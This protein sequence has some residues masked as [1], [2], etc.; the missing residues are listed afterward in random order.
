MQITIPPLQG[1]ECAVLQIFA[2]DYRLKALYKMLYLNMNKYEDVKF[3]FDSM[4]LYK[5]LDAD[6]KQICKIY[7]D[8][9]LCFDYANALEHPNN[10][11]HATIINDFEPLVVFKYATSRLAL[12]ELAMLYNKNDNLSLMKFVCRLQSKYYGKF[13][14]QGF[15]MQVFVDR[16]KAITDNEKSLGLRDRVFAH[17]DKW[18]TIRNEK[19]HEV[20]YSDVEELFEKSFDLIDDLYLLLKITSYHKTMVTPPLKPQLNKLLKL[21]INNNGNEQD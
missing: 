19:L 15:N 4:D 18:S 12:V 2:T 6:F 1:K 13:E 21:V 10:E 9:R 20:G 16:I 7:A 8:A 17:R 14:G 11:K 5:Q 3:V